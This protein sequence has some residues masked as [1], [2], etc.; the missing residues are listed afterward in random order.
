MYFLCS[1]EHLFVRIKERV[2]D[3]LLSYFD[4]VI[5]QGDVAIYENVESLLKC[6]ALCARNVAF[7]CNSC[8]FESRVKRCLI[9]SKPTNKWMNSTKYRIKMGELFVQNYFI[10]I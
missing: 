3:V 1:N 7:E 5:G 10:Q 8:E 2:S 6:S 9:S 4:F